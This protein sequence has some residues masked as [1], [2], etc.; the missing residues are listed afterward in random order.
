MADSRDFVVLL[1]NLWGSVLMLPEFASALVGIGDPESQL[2]FDSFFSDR[3]VVDPYFRVDFLGSE[4]QSLTEDVKKGKR[5][6]E[7]DRYE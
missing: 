1:D 5:Y 7:G 6:G 3:R 2:R 4:E